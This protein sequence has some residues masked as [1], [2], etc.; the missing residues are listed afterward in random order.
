MKITRGR[1]IILPYDRGYYTKQYF[2]AD[3][4]NLGIN[5]TI[6]ESRHYEYLINLI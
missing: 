4:S 3:I 5:I 6:D 2:A 1:V